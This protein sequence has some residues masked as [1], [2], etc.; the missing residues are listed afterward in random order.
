VARS[1]WDRLGMDWLGQ[2]RIREWI[3]EV[4]HGKEGRGWVRHGLVIFLYKR[5]YYANVFHI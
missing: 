2:A 3:G 5:G 4:R 1:G